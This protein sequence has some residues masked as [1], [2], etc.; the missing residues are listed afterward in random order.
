MQN[1]PVFC[2][3]LAVLTGKKNRAR[4]HSLPSVSGRLIIRT[5]SVGL[6]I[7]Q[8]LPDKKK[9]IQSVRIYF[10]NLSYQSLACS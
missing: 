9:D 7:S 5:D 10:S 3:V 8:S 2:E 6:Q 4:E 1:A